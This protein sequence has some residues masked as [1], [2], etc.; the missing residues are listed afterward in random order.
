[1]LSSA[2]PSNFTGS[3]GSALGFKGLNFKVDGY[4][5]TVAC[6]VA[7]GV[8]VTRTFTHEAPVPCPGD[9]AESKS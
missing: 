1:M 9:T 3:Q 6:Y 5:I 4:L 2:S 7:P 8:T